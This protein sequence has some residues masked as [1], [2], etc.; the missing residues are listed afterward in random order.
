MSKV[1]LKANLACSSKVAYIV[2][3]T[4]EIKCETKKFMLK[5]SIC[6]QRS[7]KVRNEG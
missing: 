2:E 4:I 3:C 1:A 5:L 7:K 6:F